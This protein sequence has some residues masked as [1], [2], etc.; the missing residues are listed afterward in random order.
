[1]NTYHGNCVI[2]VFILSICHSSTDLPSLLVVRKPDDIFDPI[3]RDHAHTILEWYTSW[4]A[5]G[6]SKVEQ[7]RAM[8][9]EK[10]HRNKVQY[11]GDGG[12]DD[13]GQ[14]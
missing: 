1:M 14:G 7:L 13:T 8:E 6:V 11:G 4:H 10:Q 12:G 9:Q 3:L 2:L 5:N